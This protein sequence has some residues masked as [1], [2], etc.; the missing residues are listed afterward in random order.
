M[1]ETSLTGPL[2]FTETPGRNNFLFLRLNHPVLKNKE[3]IKI[4][5]IYLS[6]GIA[7]IIIGSQLISWLDQKYPSVNLRPLHSFK[8]LIFLMASAITALIVMNNYYRKLLLTET[9]YKNRMIAQEKILEEQIKLYETVTT[10]TND[11]IWD[12]DIIN[13]KLRWMSGYYEVFGYEDKDTTYDGFWS[14]SKI[15]PADQ[16]RVIAAFQNIL[17]TRQ[18]N[19]RAQY[20]YLC[21]D[22]SY[23]YISDRGYLIL[24]EKGEPTRMLGAMQDIDKTMK[25]RELL[26]SQNKQLREIAWVNSHEIRRPLSNAKGLMPLIGPVIDD[27]DALLQILEML[28]ISINDLDKAVIKINKQIC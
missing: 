22:G 2:K 21:A 4:V 17:D 16:E 27:K 24:N 12:Y 15:Y 9:K 18:R 25:D 23:K 20:R 14:M 6:V 5:L 19:W 13:D 10:A 1:T 11:V 7:W 26:A 8:N 3:L 28:E